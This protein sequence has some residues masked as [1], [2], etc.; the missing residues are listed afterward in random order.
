MKKSGQLARCKWCGS[1]HSPSW[2]TAEN[3]V[4][5]CSEECQM[6]HNS[7]AN[8][9]MGI[10][11]TVLIPIISLGIIQVG[12]RPDFIIWGSIGFVFGLY[13]LDRGRRGS[14]YKYRRDIYKETQPLPCQHCTHINP[15]DVLLC[16]KCGASLRDSEFE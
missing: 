13:M 1:Y 12:D 8:T 15:P 16:Q 7:K 2:K 6:A 14:Q 3:G 4:L 11:F 10:C 5:F 9:R